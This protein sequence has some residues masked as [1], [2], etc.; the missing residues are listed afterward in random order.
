MVKLKNLSN[1]IISRANHLKQYLMW[2][3]IF[4]QNSCIPIYPSI[5]NHRIFTRHIPQCIFMILTVICFHVIYRELVGL[6]VKSRN[7]SKVFVC[8]SILIVISPNACALWESFR[9][10][11]STRYLIEVFMNTIISIE[12]KF[13][14]TIP[15]EQFLKNFRNKTIKILIC[16]FITSAYPL[17][18]PTPFHGRGLEIC[19]TIMIVYKT[20]LVIHVC[21][22]I[23][24]I[25]FFFTSIINI[26]RD[27]TKDDYVLRLSVAHINEM[28]KIL[29]HIKYFH[30]K[31]HGCCRVINERFGWILIM[32]VLQT[33][34]SS[35]RSGF[36]I[37]NYRASFVGEHLLIIR[38]Y[39]F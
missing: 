15:M 30:Y 5:K 25:S 7:K 8:I 21:F 3:Y 27:T 6:S 17:Y 37:F 12:Q 9:M 18:T 1:K 24:F 32:I 31:L 20:I 11:S 23:E 39:H 14:T 16:Y 36:Y 2:F 29:R 38:N 10:P 13:N 34:L 4:G 35:I 33:T 22:Y 26:L 19:V 28:V